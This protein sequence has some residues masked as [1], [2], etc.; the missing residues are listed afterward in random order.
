MSEEIE[1]RTFKCLPK[2]LPQK[3]CGIVLDMVPFSCNGEPYLSISRDDGKWEITGYLP[4]KD[5]MILGAAA[6]LYAACQKILPLLNDL[7]VNSP[8]S[9]KE[10]VAAASADIE[11]AVAKAR[12]EK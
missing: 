5:G 1:R 2:V 4:E 8:L 9:V 7:F 3:M 12:C 11:A 10:S 6:D